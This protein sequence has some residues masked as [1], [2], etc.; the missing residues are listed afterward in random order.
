MTAAIESSEAGID[1]SQREQ[2]RAPLACGRFRCVISMRAVPSP[3]EEALVHL[4]RVEL[5]GLGNSSELDDVQSALA[6]LDFGDEARR[7]TE[8]LGQL[9]LRQARLAA[10]GNEHGAQGAMLPAS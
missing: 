3:A 6:N 8:A 1:V 9:S 5:Q 4:A 10:A 7:L 2:D